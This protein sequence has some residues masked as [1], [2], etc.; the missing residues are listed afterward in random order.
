MKKLIILF[1]LITATTFSYSQNDNWIKIGEKIVSFKNEKDKITLT[2]NEKKVDKIKLKCV[3]GTM[4]LKSITIV[5]ENGKSKTY[6]PKGIG[7][8]TNG[9][10]S[11][12]YDVPDKDDKIKRLELEYDSKGNML[13]G[14]RAKVEIWGKKDKD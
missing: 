9:S 10:S 12:A 14:K 13:V 1:L 11:L 4:Q 7:V 3:Q 5:M 8:M 6:D 2:G